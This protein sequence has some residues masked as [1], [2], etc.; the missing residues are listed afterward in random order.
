MAVHITAQY[1]SNQHSIELSLPLF[2]IEIYFTN[3]RKEYNCERRE[4]IEKKYGTRIPYTADVVAIKMGKGG[5]EV[6]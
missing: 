4:E 2:Q 5:R 1:F 3:Y 6:E